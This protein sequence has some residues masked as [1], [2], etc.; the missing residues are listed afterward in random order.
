MGK[1]LSCKNPL[2]LNDFTDHLSLQLPCSI[3]VWKD[4]MQM[5]RGNARLD[6]FRLDRFHSIDAFQP[7]DELSQRRLR[8]LAAICHAQLKLENGS[9]HGFLPGRKKATSICV[10][11]YSLLSAVWIT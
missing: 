11:T 10:G 7:I 3:S 6:E 8:T 4:D 5:N 9:S 2:R 1:R